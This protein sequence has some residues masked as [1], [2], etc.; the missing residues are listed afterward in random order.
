MLASV[1]ETLVAQGLTI[2]SVATE[3]SRRGHTKTGENDFC[4]E[5]DCVA[6]FHLDQENVEQLVHKLEELKKDLDL[7]TLDIRVQRLG[8]ENAIAKTVRRLTAR[9]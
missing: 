8:G 3:L 1:S 2:E 7:T 5:A 6:T 4:V 9:T